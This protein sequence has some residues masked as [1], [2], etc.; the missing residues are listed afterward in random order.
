VESGLPLSMRVFFTLRHTTLSDV[1]ARALARAGRQSG[2]GRRRPGTAT[3][4]TTVAPALYN[5]VPWNGRDECDTVRGH[6][7][8]AWLAREPAFGESAIK[9]PVEMTV[10]IFVRKPRAG[11][12]SRVVR[13]RRRFGGRDSFEVRCVHRIGDVLYQDNDISD[14]ETIEGDAEALSIADLN[15]ATVRLRA[16]Y[17]SFD[18]INFRRPPRFHNLHLYF[19]NPAQCPLVFPE[20]DLAA[21]AILEDRAAL[22]RGTFFRTLV[23]EYTLPLARASQANHALRSEIAT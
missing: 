13:F 16:A 4:A 23:V 22:L 19:G 14:W 5:T 3:A 6:A 10:A 8:A 21:P 7:L 11:G 9:R 20:G 17:L 15:D 18:N 12:R 1:I 2:T